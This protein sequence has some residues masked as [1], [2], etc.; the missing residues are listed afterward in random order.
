MMKKF[1][2][3]MSMLIT[4]LGYSQ[5]IPVNFE[6]GVTV[7]VNW[8]SDSGLGSVAIVADPVT[9]GQG[10]VGQINGSSGGAAW[11][12]AQLTLTDNYIDL[13]DA[14]GSSTITFMH[15]SSVPGGGLLKLEQSLN[16]G[17]NVEKAFT[18]AGTGWE[19]ISVD[20]DTPDVGDPVNDQYKLLVFFPG[21]GNGNGATNEVTYVDDITGTV[22]DAILPAPVGPV[23]FTV[24]A[25]GAAGIRM[26]GPWWGWNPVGGPIAVNNGDDTFTVSDFFPGGAD[27][28]E[29]EYLW[30]ETT[31]DGTV[32]AGA[33]QENLI[34]NA[35]GGE[36]TDRVNSG[37]IVTDYANYA[38]RKF[39]VGPTEQYEIFDDC[40]PAQ[41]SLSVEKNEIRDLSVYPNPT[42]NSWLISTLSERIIS[43]EV[44]DLLGKQ[45]LSIVPENGTRVFI[46]AEQLAKG[47]YI[48]K[49][50]SENGVSTRKLIKN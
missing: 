30:V 25:T 3:L 28:E 34:D 38:N 48:S 31:A 6:S 49:I 26:T 16:G 35:A 22:G 50:A 33:G 15:Y 40:S 13:T 2:F 9:S 46:D 20:L 8:I 11:Q 24:T 18:T 12:N 29:F 41:S 17:G 36:C 1:T 39:T 21:I 32:T 45:V 44:Y 23:S 42:T 27:Q 7:G 47:M 37:N 14:T 5:S 43:V 19:L 4:A 10:Q